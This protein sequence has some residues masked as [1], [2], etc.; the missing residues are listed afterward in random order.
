M[1]STEYLKTTGVFVP[2][3]VVDE[4][5]TQLSAEAGV[6]DFRTYFDA[7]QSSVGRGDPAAELT[8]RILEDIVCD[9]AQLY[10]R[11]DFETAGAVDPESFELMTIAAD[12]EVVVKFKERIRAAATIQETDSRTIHTAV[13]RAYLETHPFPTLPEDIL[14]H[15]ETV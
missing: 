12:P 3:D 14:R 6:I 4:C 7:K 13:F 8:H 5:S 10:E 15:S 2:P 11:A 1:E 9:F